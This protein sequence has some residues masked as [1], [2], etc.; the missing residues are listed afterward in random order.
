MKPYKQITI[1]YDKL[2]SS[3]GYHAKD[4]QQIQHIVMSLPQRSNQIL[5]N[6]MLDLHQELT[7]VQHV[8]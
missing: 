3:D 8:Q 6:E 1:P 7:I 4:N 2:Q 5:N